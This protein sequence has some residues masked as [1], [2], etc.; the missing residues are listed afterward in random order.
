MKFVVWNT[1]TDENVA[2]FDSYDEAKA[3]L[4][5]SNN[6]DYAITGCD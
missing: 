5:E 4:L 3:F 1:K 2:Y 6:S